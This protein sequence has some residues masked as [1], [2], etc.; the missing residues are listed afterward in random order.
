MGD[1]L[2]EVASESETA[3]SVHLCAQREDGEKSR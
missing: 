3:R 2:L 1:V